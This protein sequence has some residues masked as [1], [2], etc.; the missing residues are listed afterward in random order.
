MTNQIDYDGTIIDYLYPGFRMADYMLLGN[1]RNY[2]LCLIAQKQSGSLTGWIAY[3]YSRSLREFG[4][5]TFP[6]N[7]ERIHECNAV[8]NYTMG[9]WDFGGVLVA[10]SGTPFT[11]AEA[12]YMLGGTLVTDFSQRNAC[13]AKPY[14]RLDVSATY[15]FRREQS[16][17]T[18]LC[19]SIYNV[20]GYKNDVF[21]MLEI[22]ESGDE[23][24]YAYHPM[25]L[26]IRFLPSLSF[27]YKF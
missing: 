4:G 10:A 20:S 17:E 3:T 8:L 14:F 16:R 15:Y 22:T 25:N 11:G 12:F 5:Y 26:H 27:F 13:R 21:R 18:G 23:Y 9:K 7:H 19:L 6:S 24:L 2:G 1:G